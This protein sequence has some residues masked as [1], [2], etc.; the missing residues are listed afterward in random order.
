MASKVEI[1][2]VKATLDQRLVKMDS[3]RGLFVHGI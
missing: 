2:A 1:Q 3:K